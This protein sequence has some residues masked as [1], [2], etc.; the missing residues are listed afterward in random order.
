MKIKRILSVVL[1]L[2]LCLT[3]LPSITVTSEAASTGLS[4]SQLRAKFPHG[5]YWNHAG[6]PGSSNSVNNQDG[7]TSTPCSQHGVVGTSKQTCNGFQPGSS[8]LSWQCMG[9]AEKLGYDATGYNPRNNANGW[10]TYTSSS[11]L[12]KLKPGDI[13]RYKNGGHS[14]YVTGVNGDT[15]TYTDC[16]SNGK[17]IIRWD[18]TISKST[19][20]ASFTHVRSAPSAVAP[21]PV[22]CNCSTSYA[23]TY[24]CTTSS[25]NLTI[26]SGHGSSYSA[27]GSI[28]PGATVTVNKASGTS[29]SDWAHVTY[30]GV[31]GYASMEYLAKKQQTPERDS[32]MHVWMASSEMGNSISSIRTGEWLYLCYKLY[33]AKTGDLFDTYTTS[34]YTAKLTLY[35]PD[36]SVAHTV[37]YSNDNNWIAIKRNEPGTYKGE[38][39]F[40]WNNGG[41][42]KA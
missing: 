41:T 28:P 40:T 13:V 20:R 42:S 18:A 2:L 17:C 38:L 8:Q 30:N 35:E 19:L 29:S 11:A 6:N 3:M 1:V 27:I 36:G 24:I 31:T 21:G 10:Y 14:I 15:V 32:K 39:T 16:N 5:K 33:D 7:Y 37:T 9:Y 25:L 22:S 12:D 23:G 4:L 26:R 34:G